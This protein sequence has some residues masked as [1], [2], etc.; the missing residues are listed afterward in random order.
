MGKVARQL[1]KLE[2]EGAFGVGW[3]KGEP[4]IW[5][6]WIHGD[7]STGDVCVVRCSYVRI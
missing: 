1:K 6:K 4:K 2:L 7:A 5:L 3:K